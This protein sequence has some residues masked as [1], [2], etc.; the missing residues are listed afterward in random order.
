MHLHINQFSCTL[1]KIGRILKMLQFLRLVLPSFLKSNLASVYLNAMGKVKLGNK[2]LKLRCIK[3]VRMSLLYMITTSKKYEA[4]FECNL[5]NSF[6]DTLKAYFS[7]RHR[8][9]QAETLIRLF[10]LFQFYTCVLLSEVFSRCSL[11]Q[12]NK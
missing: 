6:K 8:L 9:F 12:L 4:V 7:L 11:V 3:K 1:L 10:Y 2:I 5:L